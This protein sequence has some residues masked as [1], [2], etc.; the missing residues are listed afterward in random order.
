MSKELEVV[1]W[2]SIDRIGERYLCFSKPKDN[3]P[4]W[5]LI[6]K[7]DAQAEIEHL[8]AE[9]EREKEMRNATQLELEKVEGENE[10]L[11]DK[12]AEAKQHYSDLRD[13]NDRFTFRI[14]Q[15]SRELA[16][17]KAQSEPDSMFNWQA[18]NP[19]SLKQPAQNSGQTLDEAIA[20]QRE[21]LK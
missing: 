6:R 11:T 21:E 1:A 20:K 5:E 7:S 9:N 3:D 19:V 17:L 16:A 18:G 2:L 8:T 10:R 14:E 15:Q 4:V 13:E 12:L